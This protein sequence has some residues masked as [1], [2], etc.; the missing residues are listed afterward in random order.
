[1]YDCMRPDCRGTGG[2]SLEQ[3]WGQDVSKSQHLILRPARVGLFSSGLWAWMFQSILPYDPHLHHPWGSHIAWWPDYRLNFLSPCKDVASK[4]L[5]FLFMQMKHSQDLG[6]RNNMSLP[7][8]NLY[9]VPKVYIAPVI[10]DKRAVSLKSVSRE[11]C[12]SHTH[13]WLSSCL[14]HLP[15]E[16]VFFPVRPG[17]AMVPGYPEGRSRFWLAWL[18]CRF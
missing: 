3:E 2:A 12:F 5:K 4:H 15:D 16:A 13:A 1:M 7:P 11:G 10:S 17:A 18:S 6:T 14:T 9:L 8:P